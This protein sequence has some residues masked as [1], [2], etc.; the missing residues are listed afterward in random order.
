MTSNPKTQIQE[1]IKKAKKGDTEAFGQVYEMLLDDVFRYIYFR[2]GTGDAG[3]LAE[4]VFVKAWEHLSAYV[5]KKHS[6]FRSWIFTIA[7]NSIVDYHRQKKNVISLD[8]LDTLAALEHQDSMST[9]DFDINGLLTIDLITKA[10]QYLKE[11]AQQVVVLKYINELSYS[12]IA[13]IMHKSETAIRIII[14]RSL[15]ELKHVIEKLH[16]S[17]HL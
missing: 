16:P 6:S 5:E 7:H 1:L 11:D 8:T 3:D 17:S 9:P 13:E 15:K 2:V 4:D 12:E 10:L 14:Y